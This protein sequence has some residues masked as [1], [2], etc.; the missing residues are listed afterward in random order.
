MIFDAFALLI[1]KA[2]FIGLRLFVLYLLAAS[3]DSASFAPIAFGLTIAEIVRFV[4][5]WGIDTLSLRRFSTPD[6]IEASLRFRSVVRIKAG[7]AVLGFASSLLLLIFGAGIASVVVAALL[8]L[9]VVTSLWLNLSVN[10]LQARGQLR[11]AASYMAG[12][13]LLGFGLQFAAHSLDLEA[14]NRFAMLIAFEAGMVALISWFAWRDLSP[15]AQTLH[16][17][18]IRSWLG[19]ATPIALA[20]IIALAYSRFDQIYI[21]AFYSL[22]ILGSYTLAFRLVEPVQFL[23]VS[24]TATVY[25][26]ASR[27]VQNGDH[28][29]EITGMA[30][31]WVVAIFMVTLAFSIVTAFAGKL[32]LPVYFK[33]YSLATK[34]LYVVLLAL[35]FR[36][37]NLCLSA[38]IW[39]FS[40]YGTTLRISIVN[41]ITISFMVV[42]LGHS[43]GYFGAALAVVVGEMI[44]TIMQS[45]ALWRI[46]RVSLERRST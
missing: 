26:R 43:Y 16:I 18:T 40:K 22:D 8:S 20:T 10:W 38:F 4:T 9:T 28:L 23:M 2:T 41:A 32:Y 21:K 17:D 6:R 27:V 24:L 1:T 19:D 44:N 11:R 35:P 15:V 31:K 14:A 42:F 45:I 7:A 5:D 29:S 34:F 3:L 13:G 37:A 33:T 25:S 39:S 30:I 46:L 12:L 36:C